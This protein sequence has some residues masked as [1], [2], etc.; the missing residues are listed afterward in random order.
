M[1]LMCDLSNVNVVCTVANSSFIWFLCARFDGGIMVTSESD[2]QLGTQILS[3]VL[4]GSLCH[5]FP[6]LVSIFMVELSN[7]PKRWHG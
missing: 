7:Y 1:H 3:A 4:S 6:N 5:I 2:G